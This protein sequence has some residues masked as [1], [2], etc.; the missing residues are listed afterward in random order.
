MVMWRKLM[1]DQSLF[2]ETIHEVAE[3]IR[4][5][6]GNMTREEILG[7]FKDMDLS[8][9]QQNMVLEFLLNPH[10]EDEEIEDNEENSQD[11]TAA[12]NAA[13]VDDDGEAAYKTES[14]SSE[15]LAE[16]GH[17]YTNEAE[18][19]GNGVKAKTA[20]TPDGD[21]ADEA[22]PTGV[23]QMY[24]DELNGLSTYSKEKQEEMYKALLAGDE[25]VIAEITNCWLPVVLENA[26]KLTESNDPDALQDVVQEG[27]MALFLCLTELCGSHEKVDVESE[28]ATEIENAMKSCILEEEGEGESEDAMVGKIALVN[29]AVKYLEKEKGVKPD[30][31][32]LAEY[33][34]VPASELDEILLYI[35]KANQKKK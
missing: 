10:P 27:N 7:Y 15:E 6:Q 11:D 3:I 5:S 17:T 24:L 25:S 22:E 30:V 26:K 34:K 12:Y 35:E 2:T 4:V 23:F 31:A 19:A 21:A 32:E 29:E 1:L 14:L 18:T 20:K 28:L 13:G 16:A 33:T 9:E 8:E